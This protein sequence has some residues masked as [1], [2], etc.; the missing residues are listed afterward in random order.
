MNL[1]TEHC[2]SRLIEAR[3]PR[4]LRLQYLQSPPSARLSSMRLRSPFCPRIC[5]CSIYS[6][7]LVASCGVLRTVRRLSSR[8]AAA[9]RAGNVWHSS[10][11]EEVVQPY[12]LSS[13][14]YQQRAFPFSEPLVEPEYLSRHRCVSMC[15][16]A[17]SFFAL[18]RYPCQFCLCSAL[19]S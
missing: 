9:A 12:L 2:I 5:V 15:C 17:L 3:L 19:S 8:S 6:M 16:S 10:F 18:S 14:L 1:L 13:Q 11:K 4:A 7:A